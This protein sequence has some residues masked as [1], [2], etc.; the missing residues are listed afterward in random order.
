MRCYPIV[1]MVSQGYFSHFNIGI[2]EIKFFY[3][4]VGR[5]YGMDEEFVTNE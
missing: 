2:L 1:M 3:G 4:G 5:R